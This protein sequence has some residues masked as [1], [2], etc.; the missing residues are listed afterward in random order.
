VATQ[1]EEK[2]RHQGMA[3]ILSKSLREMKKRWPP[4]TEHAIY[5]FQ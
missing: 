4:R 1:E 2:L 3:N 5:Y